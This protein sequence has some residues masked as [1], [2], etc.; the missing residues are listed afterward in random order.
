MTAQGPAAEH[1]LRV[2]PTLLEELTQ[3]LVAGRSHP[4]ARD[5]GRAPRPKK[6]DELLLWAGRR[7]CPWYREADEIFGK[8]PSKGVHPDEAVAIGAAL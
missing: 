1:R 3:D 5:E 6:V 8:N 7:G 4:H 2:H